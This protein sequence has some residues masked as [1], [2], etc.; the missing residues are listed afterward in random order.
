MNSKSSISA[1][2]AGLH[3][4]AWALLM[5]PAVAAPSAAT[6]DR[7]LATVNGE[8]IPIRR[9]MEANAASPNTKDASA[10]LDRLV[11]VELVIQEAY[12][13]GLENTLEVRDQLGIFERDALRDGL[14]AER[15]ERIKPDAKQVE[16]MVEAMSVEVRIR[17]AVFPSKTDAERLRSRA[18]KGDDY[19]AAAKELAANGKGSVD[20]GEGFIQVSGLLPAVQAAIAALEPGRVSAVYGIG[21]RFAVTKLL[22]RR[23][24][25]DPDVRA[26]AAEEVRNRAVIEAINAFG[27]EL[28][29]KYAKVDEKLYAT[30]D[31]DAD[32]PGFDV[33]L[34]DARVLVT[35]SGSDPI[36]V[37][38][39]ADAVRKRLFHG[40]EKAAEKG[41]LN[42]KKAEVLEDLVVKR[43]VLKEARL[44]G[45]DKKPDYL[46]L[47]EDAERELVFG[48]FVSRVI[49]P[50]AKVTDEDVRAFYESHRK[51]FTAPDMVRLDGMGFS[52]TTSAEA[53]LAKLRSGADLNWMRANAPGRI[54]PKSYPDALVFQT[55]PVIVTDLPE[56]L[57]QSI[58]RAGSGE[59]RLYEGDKGVTYVV[60]VREAMP[61]RTRPLEDVEDRIRGRLAGEK[62]QKAFDAY[63][64][65]LRTASD[66]KILVDAGELARLLPPRPPASKP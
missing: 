47:R 51:D 7:V 19:D 29:A 38:D 14:F 48:S 63:T 30:L 28:K 4:V 17:S 57:R 25:F 46:A 9:L 34:K 8:P 61:G 35:I 12:R 22:E 59:Y 62:R 66:V 15:V 11:S 39:L 36:T 50:A 6:G 31:F 60:Q 40:P 18:L 37:G 3:A 56:G 1:L 10:L 58:A 49:E 21:D 53:A 44:K 32:E 45:L 54:D 27:E 42:R 33:F 55:S 5:Q 26:K 13:M 24:V 52:S 41:R 16:A 43:V 64:A 20:P 65:R 23:P 2:T